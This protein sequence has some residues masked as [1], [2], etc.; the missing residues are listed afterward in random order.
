[1][2]LQEVLEQTAVVLL[3]GG[4]L[5]PAEMLFG[6]QKQAIVPLHGERFADV[7]STQK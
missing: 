2:R 6:R 7:L 3:C 5:V 4:M 1:M